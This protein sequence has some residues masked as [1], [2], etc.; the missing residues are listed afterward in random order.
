MDICSI[1]NGGSLIKTGLY[2]RTINIPIMPIKLMI[3]NNISNIIHMI[4]LRYVLDLINLSHSFKA[5]SMDNFRRWVFIV[6][7]TWF[8]YLALALP[9]LLVYFA[10]SLFRVERYSRIFIILDFWM[11]YTFIVCKKTSSNELAY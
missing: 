1:T 3:S 9:S 2:K 6:K 11:V 7:W 8:I 10:L 4:F 5:F